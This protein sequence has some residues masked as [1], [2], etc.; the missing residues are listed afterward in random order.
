LEDVYVDGRMP[1][2]ILNSMVERGLDL[3]SLGRG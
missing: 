2:L 3:F 1:K